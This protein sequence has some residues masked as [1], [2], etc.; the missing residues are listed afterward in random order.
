MSP[1]QPP[2]RQARW[3]RILIALFIAAA[4]LVL[5][6]LKCGS[7]WGFGKGG[8]DGEGKAK[9][10]P[11]LSMLDAGVP[12]CQLRIDAAGIAANGKSVEVDGAVDA[13]R[14]AGAADV[15]VTGDARQGLWDQLE[16][17]LEGAGVKA[18]VRGSQ[19]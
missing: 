13:C 2:R 14:K 16:G 7:G 9:A 3:G 8:D 12:R 6:F 10:K 17:A 1:K 19:P 15:V 5:L 4:A 11:A 18:F